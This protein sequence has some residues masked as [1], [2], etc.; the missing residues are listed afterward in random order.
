MHINI[1]Y[2]KQVD[3]SSIYT[4]LMMPGPIKGIKPKQPIKA[5]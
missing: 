3:K 2:T 4:H 1:V 5:N